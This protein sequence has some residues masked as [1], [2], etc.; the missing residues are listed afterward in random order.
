MLGVQAGRAAGMT[1]CGVTTSEPSDVLLAAGA[2]FAI[3]DFA[4]LPGP[5]I[6]RLPA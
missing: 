6:A 1:V 4:R 3:S 2:E 5:L